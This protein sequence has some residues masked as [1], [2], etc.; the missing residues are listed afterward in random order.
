MNIAL[1]L[2]V[3]FVVVVCFSVFFWFW[4]LGF[5]EQDLTI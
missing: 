1:P 4:L 2:K 5:F 3:Y